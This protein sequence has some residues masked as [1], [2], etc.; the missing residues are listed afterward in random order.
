MLINQNLIMQVF[1]LNVKMYN[2]PRKLLKKVNKSY[3]A[4]YVQNSVRC[5][6]NFRGYSRFLG[7]VT[8]IGNRIHSNFPDSY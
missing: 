3:I 2:I 4:I 5:D 7:L 8:K 1:I 6:S